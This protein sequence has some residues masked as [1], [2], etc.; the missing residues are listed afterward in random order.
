[1]DI[2]IGN[3]SSSG[4]THLIHNFSILLDYVY[5]HVLDLLLFFTSEQ[6]PSPILN[7]YPLLCFVTEIFRHN[8]KQIFKRI[9][10][11]AFPKYGTE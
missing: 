7:S 11:T 3:K 8:K 5:H 1:M 4:K 2:L 9:E 6:H 10:H